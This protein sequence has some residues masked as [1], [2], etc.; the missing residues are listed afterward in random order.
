MKKLIGKKSR[1]MMTSSVIIYS[2][3]KII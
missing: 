2:K 3:E 1:P